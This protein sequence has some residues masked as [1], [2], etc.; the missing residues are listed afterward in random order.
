MPKPR[1]PRPDV[2]PHAVLTASR[3]RLEGLTFQAKHGVLPEERRLGGPFRVDM[4]LELEHPPSYRDRLEDTV[5]Y[6]NAVGAAARVMHGR[7]R[8][9]LE[10]LAQE[11]GRDLL[12]TGGI[13][14]ATV[15][16]TKLAPPLTPGATSAAELELERA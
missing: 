9:T 13:R 1:R 7:P 4:V 8:L 2:R 6:R 3:L 15:R 12:R 10:F 16:V 5:D 14:K 11:I